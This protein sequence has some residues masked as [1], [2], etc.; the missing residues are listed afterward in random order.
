LRTSKGEGDL[1][2]IYEDITFVSPTEN[3]KITKEQ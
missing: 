2:F 1:N 3:N